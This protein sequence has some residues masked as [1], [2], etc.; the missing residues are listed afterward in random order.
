MSKRLIQFGF[1]LVSTLV[2]SSGVA[3]A[4]SEVIAT[5][6]GSG[7]SAVQVSVQQTAS[8][9]STSQTQ[10]SSEST[11]YSASNVESETAGPVVDNTVPSALQQ[12]PALIHQSGEINVVAKTTNTSNK[13][14]ETP[15]HTKSNVVDNTTK[16]DS[17]VTVSRAIRQLSERATIVTPLGIP[18]A[19]ATTATSDAQTP[20]QPV[21]PVEAL[22]QHLHAILSDTTV[23]VLALATPD[24]T[25]LSIA[26]LI[27]L[28]TLTV[29]ALVSQALPLRGFTALLRRSGYAHAA[30]SAVLAPVS[31][32]HSTQ[33]SCIRL[34]QAAT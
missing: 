19:L 22:L 1:S 28:L 34:P 30:R 2:V 25:F 4:E 5:S 33:M 26:V 16:V 6:S 17:A 31:L 21:A 7:D 29:V 20:P 8:Q 23:P 14:T 24:T 18:T 15:V 3:L 27:S 13:P 32:C 11:Q 10:T 12:T 9:T